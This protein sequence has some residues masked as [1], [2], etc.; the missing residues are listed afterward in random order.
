LNEAVEMVV[1]RSANTKLKRKLERKDPSVSRIKHL[2]DE[3]RKVG[4]TGFLANRELIRAMQLSDKVIS[5]ALKSKENG[6]LPGPKDRRAE[7]LRGSTLLCKMGEIAILRKRKIM[8]G[9]RTVEPI[10]IPDAYAADV[11]EIF[12]K[13]NCGTITRL[14]NMMKAEVWFNKM[15]GLIQERVNTCL[16]CIYMRNKPKIVTAQREYDDKEP[17]YIGE[18]LFADVITR[19]AHRAHD[20]TTMKFLIVSDAIS[21]YTRLYSIKNKE[22]NAA[23]AT[24]VLLEALADFNRGIRYQTAVK[25]IMDGS[26][27]NQ[28]VKKRE[29]WK[30]LNLEVIITEKTGGS[31]NY[32][33]PLDSRIAKLSPVLQTEIWNKLTPTITALNVEGKINST[34][35]GHGFSAYEIWQ[36]RSQ[37]SNVPLQIN[38]NE[39]R[40]YLKEVRKMSRHAKEQN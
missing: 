3:L 5:K 37:F 36:K 26:S 33:A 38:I 7:T 19:N 29:L 27:V 39:I 9:T 40:E 14:T 24:E 32:L 6:K 11:I 18:T 31:K 4:T 34:K 25:I 22:N 13:G 12:H 35:G 21:S 20:E 15:A 23:R 17:E 28:N 2:I 10:I 1:L 16:D 30:D 8:V